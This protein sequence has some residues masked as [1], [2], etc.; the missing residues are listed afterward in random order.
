MNCYTFEECELNKTESFSVLV[1]EEM[2]TGFRDFSGDYNPLHNN[3]EYAIQKGFPGKVVY[4][5]LS[6]SFLSTLVGMYLPGKYCLIQ[7]VNIKFVKPVYVGDLLEVSGVISEKNELFQRL[8][9]KVSI[10]NQKQEL[11][12]RGK[13]QIGVLS[14]E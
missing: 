3:E 6:A 8:T 7:E 11:V 13:M 12:V 5:M 4:G 9:L 1:T 10:R 14:K 2:L